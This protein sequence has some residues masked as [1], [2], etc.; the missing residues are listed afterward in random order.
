TYKLI[1]NDFC[2][3]YLE[4]VKPDYQQ[5][6]DAA[7]LKA[8]ITYFEQ[9][10]KML[11]PFMPFVTEELWQNLE[12]RKDGETIMLLAF[13]EA[14]T[15][16]KELLSAFDYATNVI[17][18]IRNFR[19]TKY[20]ANKDQLELMVKKNE[21]I[22]T[23]LDTIISKLTNLSKLEYV[24]NK[25]EGAYSFV[26]KSNEYFIPLAGNVDVDAELEKIKAELEYAKGLLAIVDKKLANEK[27]VNGAPE[28][29][30]AAEKKKKADA[31]AKIKVLEEQLMS[32]K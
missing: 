11:H 32:L 2:S 17:T 20:I 28:Q 22:N 7:T 3:W 23:A 10:L 24:D 25:I 21:V 6:I 4:S 8:T 27:F 30:V 26:V 13:P 14:G 18:E 31:E 9:L 1:W 15:T 16:D 19:K 5:P 12:E 29:V